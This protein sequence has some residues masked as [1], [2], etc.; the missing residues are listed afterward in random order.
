M[1]MMIRT[2]KHVN[3]R[4]TLISALPNDIAMGNLLGLIGPGSGRKVP[5]GKL[6]KR[7]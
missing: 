4:V 3:Q 1:K 6:H 7:D 5:F 2:E